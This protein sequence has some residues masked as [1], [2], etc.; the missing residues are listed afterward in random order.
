MKTSPSTPDYELP[1]F[2]P[3]DVD[4]E[5]VRSAGFAD[6]IDL[7][8][9]LNGATAEQRSVARRFI[10]SGGPARRP[11]PTALLDQYTAGALLDPG[12]VVADLH[13]LVVAFGL[14]SAAC[15]SAAAAVQGNPGTITAVTNRSG[16]KHVRTFA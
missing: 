13:D 7:V 16:V 9:G 6:L 5:Q 12:V 11:S 3:V 1:A 15:A 8:A 10:Q 14:L 4:I 2:I